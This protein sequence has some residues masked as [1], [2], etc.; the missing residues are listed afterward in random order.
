MQDVARA[1]GLRSQKFQLQVV[2]YSSEQRVAVTYDDRVD[3]Y[4]QLVDEA[5]PKKA[6]REIVAAE[7]S[8]VLAG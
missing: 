2:G 7:Y 8:D 3:H 1:K 5:H 4:S 6:C